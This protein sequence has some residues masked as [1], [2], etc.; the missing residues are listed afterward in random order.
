MTEH[1]HPA[2]DKSAL[3]I[4]TGSGYQAAILAELFE[5]VDTVEYFIDLSHAAQRVIEELGY[6]NITFHIGDGLTV[7]GPGH[8]FDAI[9]VTAA[10]EHF[11]ES[12]IDRLN[13]G[14]RLV[15]P[16][17]KGVQYLELIVKE[18]DGR[19]T[20]QTLYGVRFVPLQ[21]DY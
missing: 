10:P 15:V 13:P 7:P 14:G 18:I 21:G 5:H 20:R 16:V 3:E 17:G 19:L 6:D 8:T 2:K 12:L 9:I 1:L 11:P 4:G